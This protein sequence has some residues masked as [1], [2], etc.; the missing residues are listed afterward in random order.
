VIATMTIFNVGVAWH[1]ITERL[2]K[3]PPKTYSKENL[4]IQTH[5][6]HGER[7]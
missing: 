3:H 4:V 6:L 2:P 1:A 7:K 5:A